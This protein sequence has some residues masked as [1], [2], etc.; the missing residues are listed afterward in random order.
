MQKQFIID[1]II[2]IMRYNAIYLYMI[3]AK[4][5]TQIESQ[6]TT[7]MLERI[8]GQD[9]YDQIIALAQIGGREVDPF[10]EIPDLPHFAPSR[11]ALTQEDMNGRLFVQNLMQV[12]ELE[13]DDSHPLGIIGKLKG[14][15]PDAKPIIIMSHY[16]TV[17][18]ADMFDGVTGILSGIVAAKA[19]KESGAHHDKPIWI[20]GVTGEE[21]ARFR[22]ALFGSDAMFNGLSDKTLNSTDA[23][24]VTLRQAIIDAGGDLEIVKKPFLQPADA[25]TVFELHVDQTGQNHRDG[26]DIGL[27]EAVAAPQ[28]FEITIGEELEPDETVYPCSE[29]V[30][31]NVRGVAGHSGATPMNLRNRADALPPLGEVV[32]YLHGLMENIHD[33]SVSISIGNISIENQAL[34]KIPGH[35][36]AIIRISGK[37]QSHVSSLIRLLNEFIN[38]INPDYKAA[39]PQFPDSPITLR[40]MSQQ[41]V[42]EKNIHFYEHKTSLATHKLACE[43][44]L[45]I[46]HISEKYKDNRVVGTVGTYTIHNGQVILGLDVRG[47]DEY[48]DR[49][50]DEMLYMIDNDHNQA[51]MPV[52]RRLLD[53]S[54]DPVSMDPSL[55]SLGEQVIAQYDIG[56]VKRTISSAG[57]DAMNAAVAG[58]PTS[59]IFTRSNGIAH[60]PDGYTSPDEIE[61][62]A[63]ALAAIV[64][65][66]ANA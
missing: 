59:L 39:H 12:A 27:V 62:G 3:E 34:N 57:H 43:I 24:G 23:N 46:Q 2:S 35:T 47:I 6:R 55:I 29:Y 11:L 32:G 4:T 51:T 22:R 20:L 53:G 49:A 54:G 58:I 33:Q 8:H 15:N 26:V 64:L 30:A 50:L 18:E 65:T 21:S 5:S 10:P 52:Q 7:E 41:E 66:R 19:I 17:P 42:A 13:V 56:S 45:H 16:D 37:D 36:Q 44:A 63:R 1:L 28:R 61:K 14:S 31:I 60:N 38:E 25:D 9:I 48:R 40:G